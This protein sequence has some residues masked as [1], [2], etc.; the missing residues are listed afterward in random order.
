MNMV[1]LESTRG[2][3]IYINPRYVVRISKI[4]GGTLVYYAAGSACEHVEVND[5][6]D[7]VMYILNKQE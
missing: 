5:D 4:K 3:K 7:T 2:G 6:P 1:K